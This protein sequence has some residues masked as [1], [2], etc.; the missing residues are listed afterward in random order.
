[1]GAKVN[2]W[3]Q[4]VGYA[5]AVGGVVSVYLWC[6]LTSAASDADARAE[7]GEPDGFDLAEEDDSTG[8]GVWGVGRCGLY[9]GREEVRVTGFR[10]V[11]MPWGPLT[12]YGCVRCLRRL[13]FLERQRTRELTAPWRTPLNP[14]PTPPKT[15][16]PTGSQPQPA[17]RARGQEPGSNSPLGH[18]PLWC[19]G[20][21]REPD[22]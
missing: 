1:M 2:G 19:P 8:R 13:N 4:T 22:M 9:C 3:A 16:P 6:V 21:C 12:L 11:P 20:R 18:S 5:V 10:T 15:P 17:P 7:F 14:H